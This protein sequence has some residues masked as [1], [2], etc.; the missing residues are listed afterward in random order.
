MHPV[1]IKIYIKIE[2]PDAFTKKIASTNYDKNFIEVESVKPATL[3]FGQTELNK[4]TFTRESK[5]S[6]ARV[7]DNVGRKSP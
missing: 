1:P 5:Q 4:R 7:P 3:G 6:G 2:S